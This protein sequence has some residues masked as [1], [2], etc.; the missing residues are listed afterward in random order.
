VWV[1]I[2]SG[3]KNIFRSRS[4]RPMDNKNYVFWKVQN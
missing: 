2:C 4:L 3:K 1:P